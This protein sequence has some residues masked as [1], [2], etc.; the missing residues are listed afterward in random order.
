[1]KSKELYKISNYVYNESFLQSHLDMSGAN[2]SS[3]MEKM[4]KNKKYIK[5]QVIFTK[6]IMVLYVSFLIF[7]PITGY[8]QIQNAINEGV[9]ITWVLFLGGAV[10]GAYFL[11]QFAYLLMF[12]MFSS[13]GLFTGNLF[14]WI[15]TLPIKRK[16]MNKIGM[17]T[18]FRVIDAQFIALMLIFPLATAI[19][20]KSIIIT[21]ISLGLSTLNTIFSFNVLI[22]LSKKFAGV[23]KGADSNAKGSNLARILFLVGYL[24]TTMF[25]VI[26][27]Q[28]LPE[29]INSLYYQVPPNLALF[30]TLNQW[31][32][33]IPF[34]VSGGYLLTSFLIGLNNV[35]MN[36]IL[37]I[38]VGLAIFALIDYVMLKKSLK[39]MN[40]VIISRSDSKKQNFKV[41]TVSDVSVTV[42]SPIKAFFQ[43]DKSMI[44]RDIQA[45]I[46]IIIPVILPWIPFFIMIRPETGFVEIEGFGVMEL[47]YCVMGATMNI[48]GLTM[49]EKSGAT[50]NASLPI[51]VRD[52]VKARLKWAFSIIPLGTLLP[53]VM[54]IGNSLFWDV[55]IIQISISFV[56]LLIGTFSL[57]L[58]I[59]LFGKMK[60]KY[61][62]DEIHFRYKIA[63]NILIVVIDF[64][65]LVLLTIGFVI[66]LN[67]WNLSKFSI[68]IFPIELVLALILYLVY[69]KMFPKPKKIN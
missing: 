68:I 5:N 41:S 18:L 62:L 21:L 27:I 59:R 46:F 57:L 15:S 30:E 61:V 8:L 23:I 4:E 34:P 44:L 60:K 67:S 19:I 66:L 35:G 52:Q 20:T 12:G 56:G 28:F 42:V 58:W 6:I 63:K 24:A 22:I 40:D 65:L 45:I 25:A 17:M 64:I 51:I 14:H 43:R 10:N 31:I 26:G 54:Y 33:L 69:N 13:T 11:F 3:V 9:S 39:I 29:V 32:S 50:I 37:P 47:I 48:L 36:L 2:V 38:L 55:F 1:M 16:D 53:V 7:L 49:V